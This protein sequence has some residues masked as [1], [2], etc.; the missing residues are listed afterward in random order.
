MTAF[1]LGEH[2][3][4][5]EGE[6]HFVAHNATLIG[7]VVLKTQAS[8]WFNAVIRADNALIEIGAR[9]NVQD[10][11]V[12]HT[13]PGITLRLG[14]DVTVGHNA[15]LHGCE[16]GSNSLIGIGAVVLNHA[17]IGKNCIVGANALIT[18]RSVIPD[19]SL[20]V[21]SPA[22]VIR[23]LDEAAVALLRAN[24]EVYVQHAARYRAT[25]KEVTLV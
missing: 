20:V 11:A 18:E 1:Q 2:A 12:L 9:S 23:Q 17:R 8:V 4:Q 16:V 22:K 5:L 13:D 24:A 25:L 7:Q 10:G 21:G 6:G 19:N 15:M 14:E 3:P